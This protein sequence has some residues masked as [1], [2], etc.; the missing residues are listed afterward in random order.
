MESNRTFYDLI[1]ELSEYHNAT[2]LRAT[3]ASRYARYSP[4][5]S[6]AKNAARPRPRAQQTSSERLRSRVS[7]LWLLLCG[8]RV[9]FNAVGE[10]CRLLGSP[11]LRAATKASGSA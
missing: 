8:R 5:G 9:S 1:S 6:S 10:S 2:T 3:P 7:R 11:W 4:S